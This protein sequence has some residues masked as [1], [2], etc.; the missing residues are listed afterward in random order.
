MAQA[1]VIYLDAVATR[2]P[3]PML[4]QEPLLAAPE[5]RCPQCDWEMGMAFEQVI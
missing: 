4:L 5:Q 2:G 1:R 3:M